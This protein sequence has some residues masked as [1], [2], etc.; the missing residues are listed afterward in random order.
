MYKYIL[1]IVLI[2]SFLLATN[3]NSQIC[4]TKTVGASGA[5]YTNLTQAFTAINSTQICG[6]L[7][8]LIKS[9]YT[10][11]GETF[12]LTLNA[13]NYQAGGPYNITIKPEPAANII[14]SGSSAS[15]VLRFNGA[16][17][18]TIDGSNSN[19]TDRSIS[20]INTSTANN[21]HGIQL[22]SLGTNAGSKYITIKNINIQCGS[23]IATTHGIYSQGEDNDTLIVQ[24]CNILKARTGIFISGITSNIQQNVNLKNNV[25]GS[26]IATERIYANG[27]E[28]QACSNLVIDGNEI[29]GLKGISP[30]GGVAGMLIGDFIWNAVFSNNKIHSINSTNASRASGIYISLASSGSNLTFQNNMLWNIMNNGTGDISSAPSAFH[31]K[32]GT[33]IKLY[34]NSISLYGDRD[35]LSATKPTIY[36]AGIIIESG[37]SQLVMNNNIV[38]N[39]MTAPT[40][41]ALSY[42]VYLNG[43]PSLISSSNF[44]NFF[45]AGP[46]AMLMYYLSN[47]SALS[48]WQSSTG[49]DGNSRSGNPQYISDLNLHIRTD[50]ISI[51]N[52]AAT[53]ISGVTTDI[54]GDARSATTPDIGADEFLGFGQKQ[55]DILVETVKASFPAGRYAYIVGSSATI[56]VVIRNEG[57]EANPATVRVCYKIGSPPADSLDGISETFTPTWINKSATVTFAT[58]YVPTVEGSYQ[59]YVR[60][61][62]PGDESVI[63]D[64][65]S[66]SIKVYKSTV[67]LAE[68]FTNIDFPPLQWIRVDGNSDGSV[69]TRTT[70]NSN[71]PPGAATYRFH[72]LNIANDWIITAGI[73]LSSAKTYRLKYSYRANDADFT[74]KMQVSY[75]TAQSVAGMTNTLAV[76]S[77]IT[78]TTYITNSV[79]F[80]PGTST[81]YY[82]GFKCYSDAE[83]D[84]LFLDDIFVEELENHDI[85]A[86]ISV[87]PTSN[88]NV[89]INVVFNPQ[90]NFLGVGNTNQTNISVRYQIYN[91]ANTQIYN[92]LKTITSIFPTQ[93]V[94]VTFA[95]FTP[96][97]LGNYT[98]KIFVSAPIDVNRNNDTIKTSFSVLPTLAGTYT[99]GASG[100]YTTL[101]SA[102]SD[103][104]SKIVVSPVTFQLIDNSY[105][106]TPLVI[107][108]I[109]GSSLSSTVTIKPATGRTPV[110]NT[111]TNASQTFCLK[112]NNTDY[113]IL[114]GSN[115]SSTSKDLTLTASGIN[116]TNAVILSNGSSNNLIKNCIMEASS[117]DSTSSNGVLR[118]ESSVNGPSSTNLIENNSLVGGF[119]GITFNGTDN[120]NSIQ[121]NSVKN[122][123][124]TNFK[125][126]GIHLGSYS[127]SNN[128]EANSIFNT[129]VTSHNRI[130]G[131]VINSQTDSNNVFHRNKIYNLFPN[132]DTSKAVDVKGILISGG[133]RNVLLNNFISIGN[134][135]KGSVAGIENS[136]SSNTSTR[137][138]FN[139]I[140][141]FDTSNSINADYCYFQSAEGTTVSD[142]LHGNIFSNTR[143]GIASN[144]YSIGLIGGA[145]ALNYSDYNLVFG[146]AATYIAGRIGATNYTDLAALQAAPGYAPKDINSTAASPGFT[147]NADLHINLTSWT[148]N[149]QSKAAP[150]VATDIDGEPRFT[151]PNNPAD[152][153][154]DEYT[155]TDFASTTPDVVP[156]NNVTQT[157]AH[158]GIT[159]AKVIWG[160]TGTVPGSVTIKLFN[161]QQPFNI[162]HSVYRY[163]DISVSGAYTASA[164][165]QLF[166]NRS[167]LNG[168]SEPL[169]TIN[170]SG[171]GSNNWTELASSQFPAQRYVSTELSNLT[172]LYGLGSIG[173]VLPIQLVYFQGAINTTQNNLV[174]LEWL[175]LWE[176]NNY[177]FFIDRRKND[178]VDF[179]TVAFI[180]PQEGPPDMPRTYNWQDT[181]LENGIYYYRLRQVDLNN[182][183]HTFDEIK[184]TATSVLNVFEE[185]PLVFQLMQ[186]Y[187]NPFNPST[188]IKFSV[189]NH[190]KTSLKVY[191]ILG[192]LVTTLFD[193]FAEAGRYYRVNFDGSH[194]SS[195]VYFLRLDNDKNIK[196]RKMLLVR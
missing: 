35:T 176:K 85:A 32:N 41:S 105:S 4:G 63:N 171:D 45:V 167:E 68:D 80:T 137:I 185:A 55:K 93:L 156:G 152:I 39:R 177:G 79:Q 166:Y 1:S 82:F 67:Y 110:I 173:N 127:K 188:T 15:G 121:N 190:G 180:K 2:S 49:Q 159:A 27:I 151:S 126:N 128:I 13:L 129:N 184:I 61:F 118:I 112:L 145:T 14:I 97:A 172:G 142:T 155:P 122:C 77:S 100:N 130:T 181:L 168:I 102:I 107:D 37:I 170:R 120:F 3:V 158:T 194:Y 21:T 175:T 136:S 28:L 94:T 33:D 141:I 65:T 163:F 147:S 70:I 109:K 60:S 135:T 161:G 124:I 96:T 138:L 191:N 111:T 179:D 140:N 84:S 6:N 64:T 162:P 103:L 195:G 169:L 164:T 83:M 17:Y 95:N 8:L 51:V 115:Q 44:N 90:A 146:N 30:F 132:S 157:F 165:L 153:G 78:N 99:V 43:A 86:G 178:D 48:S 150:F 71:S 47:R 16:D 69:W 31:L 56:S 108:S 36:G 42:A 192:K 154:A 193:E 101:S 25:I 106:T 139:S 81:S 174:G 11:S 116:G 58:S 91:S 131:L 88:S 24:N 40:N 117:S 104:N 10:S 98:T 160:S 59:L 134:N 5:D 89:P 114:D 183:T 189:E 72:H 74:E 12:P 196:I 113:F 182:L 18:L 187:P 53:P 19:G 149:G 23:L 62:Y 7:T 73:S 66:M 46:Q 119:I 9:N 76:H 125:S 148:P 144:K 133:V 75:G 143:S 38:S 26:N 57:E 87:Y 186:N 52:N 29:Y 22:S 54:D 92:D 34:Y 123:A 20:I 50:T